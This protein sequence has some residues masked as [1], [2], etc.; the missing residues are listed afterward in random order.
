MKS[1]IPDQYMTVR[2]LARY[3]KVHER[4]VRRWIHGGKL[5]ALRIG[6]EYRLSLT[7]LR[8]A[9]FDMTSPDE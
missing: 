4:T 1:N 7:A 8:E 6:G 3:L 9:G 5:R 2:D